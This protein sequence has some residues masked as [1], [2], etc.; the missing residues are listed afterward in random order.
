MHTVMPSI[1][2]AYG[3]SS[4]LGYFW[5]IHGQN[6]AGPNAELTN[7]LFQTAQKHIGSRRVSAA[8]RYLC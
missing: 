5:V 8:T 3:L 2:P 7:Y 4:L 1:L 6:T